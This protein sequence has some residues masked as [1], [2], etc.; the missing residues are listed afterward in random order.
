MEAFGKAATRVSAHGGKSMAQDVAGEEFLSALRA[1]ESGID[2]AQA[3]WYRDNL[4]VSSIDYPRV[5][6]PGRLER[7]PSSGAPIY[8]RIS[9][10]QYFHTLGVL[11]RYDPADPSCLAGMQYRSMNAWGFVGYQFGESI[12]I[13]NG[14]YLPAVASSGLPRYY[15]LILPDSTWAA[16]CTETVVE[17]PQTERRV[18]S[19]DV[20][21]WQGTFTGKFGLNSLEDLMQPWCQERVIRELMRRNL[22]VIGRDLDVSMPLQAARWR[23]QREL[24]IA[25]RKRSVEISLSGVLAA[26][27]LC[28]AQ[29]TVRFL[30]SGAIAVDEKG[31]SIIDYMERF[32]N[33]DVDLAE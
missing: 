4:D 19:T 1:F 26:A 28:G 22:E 5:R 23:Q 20:N 27:H 30:R 16:G 6:R 29:A 8:E 9:I 18:Q 2:P 15:A 7:D 25:G 3:H 12:L 33:M 32:A 31:T 13:E 10:R 21:T 14:F 24:T 11:D 17:L